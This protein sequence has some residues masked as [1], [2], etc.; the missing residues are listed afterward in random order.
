LILGHVIGLC[1]ADRERGAADH[2][3]RNDRNKTSRF[4]DFKH[5][6]PPARRYAIAL[7]CHLAGNGRGILPICLGLRPRGSPK[8][9][10]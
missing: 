7:D 1:H 4:E 3:Q 6:V 10:R 8:R 9:N 2:Q 5:F